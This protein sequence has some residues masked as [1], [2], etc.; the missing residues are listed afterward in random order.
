MPFS[1]E[2]LESRTLLSLAGPAA[3]QAP[4]A[5]EPSVAVAV[6]GRVA[7]DVVN[8]PDPVLRSAIRQA[9]GKPEGAITRR[10]MLHLKTLTASVG[11]VWYTGGIRSLEERG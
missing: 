10:A 8:I 5:T 9:L 1:L 11:P 4:V 7:T 2:N 6:C 3:I